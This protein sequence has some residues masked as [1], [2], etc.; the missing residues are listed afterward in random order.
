MRDMT[1]AIF[2]KKKFSKTMIATKSC[3]FLTTAK[4]VCW[5]TLARRSMEKMLVLKRYQFSMM[6][7]SGAF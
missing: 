6:M 3:Q 5:K 1:T 7:S 4:G 2:T